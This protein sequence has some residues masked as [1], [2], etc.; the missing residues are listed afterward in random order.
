MI[1]LCYITHDHRHVMIMCNTA[2][3]YHRCNDNVYPCGNDAVTVFV[4]QVWIKWKRISYKIKVPQW[5]HRRRQA[6]LAS[7]SEVRGSVG[8][9]FTPGPSDPLTGVCACACV[10]VCRGGFPWLPW[11]RVTRA[12]ACPRSPFG[13]GGHCSPPPRDTPA[14]PPGSEVKPIASSLGANKCSALTPRRPGG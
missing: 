14:R 8:G 10:C 11:R 1:M 9:L 2:W 3:H 7:G 13:G 12:R 6:V 4:Y 5:L